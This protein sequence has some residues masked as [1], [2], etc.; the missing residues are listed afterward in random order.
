[1]A[2]CRRARRASHSRSTDPRRQPLLACAEVQRGLEELDEKTL[3]FLNHIS[4]IS[5][6]LPDGTTAIVMR[7]EHSDLTIT[8]TKEVGRTVTDSKWLRLVGDSTVAHPGTLHSR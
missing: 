2:A 6:S 5:Y 4:T 7:E 3:L 8:I 1:M